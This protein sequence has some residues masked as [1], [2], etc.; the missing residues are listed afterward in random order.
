M[1]DKIAIIDA[2]SIIYI[3]V[4]KCVKEGNTSKSF[5]GE[6][7]YKFLK[8]ITKKRGCNKYIAFIGDRYAE[9]FR[10]KLYPEYK[11]TRNHEMEGMDELRPTI[12]NVMMADFKFQLLQDIE[13]D[14]GCSITAKY[15]ERLNAGESKPLVEYVVCS[16][17]KDL[18]QIQG[19]HYDYKKQESWWITPEDAVTNLWKQCLMGDSSDNIKGL[20]G[21]GPKSWENLQKKVGQRTN[22]QWAGVAL[23]LFTKKFSFM[24]ALNEMTL[25]YNLVKM[26][27]EHCRGV[28]LVF[29]D[30][31]DID[32]PVTETNQF[33]N[34]VLPDLSMMSKMPMVPKEEKE[35]EVDFE[36]FNDP[37]PAKK[38]LFSFKDEKEHNSERNF[39]LSS[40]DVSNLPI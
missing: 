35:E 5:I 27:E 36:E 28:N 20:P 4:S 22:I 17:D 10:H 2:D 38:E 26:R 15:L 24:E 9:T 12:Q 33:D 21:F 39:K 19:E 14:D 23:K 37:T 16:P 18:N 25:N 31:K 29:T 40:D 3:V 13:A 8:D 1:T 7:I 6:T 32:C 11:G 34:V 30:I